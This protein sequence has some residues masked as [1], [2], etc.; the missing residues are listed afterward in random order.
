M[1]VPMANSVTR[2]CFQFKAVTEPVFSKASD[3]YYKQQ[4]QSL[5][6]S[7]FLEKLEA[8][9]TNMKTLLMTVTK[10]VLQSAFGGASGLYQIGF[11]FSKVLG[12]YQKCQ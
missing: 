4:R 9:P 12:L 11:V 1:T 5:E 3:L 10:S 2:I 6:W 8:F 7:M